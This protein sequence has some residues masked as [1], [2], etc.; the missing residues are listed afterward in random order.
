MKKIALHIFS[1][2]LMIVILA[3]CNKEAMMCDSDDE[4]K[5]E[6]MATGEEIPT[7]EAGIA[8]SDESESEEEEDISDDDDEEDDDD[9]E[10]I[11]D[12]DDEEDDDES[13]TIKGNK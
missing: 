7:N 11:S 3:S 13:E 5:L 2:L 10:D 12:D 9:L 6:R 1:L 8:G 4:V